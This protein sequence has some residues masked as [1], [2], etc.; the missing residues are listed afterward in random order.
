MWVWPAF[1]GW[2]RAG[3]GAG[4]LRWAGR[5][6]PRIQAWLVSEGEAVS[7]GSGEGGPFAGLFCSCAQRHSTASCRGFSQCLWLPHP[8][9]G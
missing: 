3:P 6:E 5:P 7:S 2:P 4:L 1:G 9:G 8:V